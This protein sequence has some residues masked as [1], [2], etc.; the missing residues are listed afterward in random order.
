MPAMI[1][2][3]ND[4]RSGFLFGFTLVISSLKFAAQ[5]DIL[6]AYHSPFR[7]PLIVIITV[8]TI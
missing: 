8:I 3:L 1:C 5:P 6:L 4:L 7:Q 2:W